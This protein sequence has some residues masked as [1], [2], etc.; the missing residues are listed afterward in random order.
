LLIYI[1]IYMKNFFFLM[2]HI[3]SWNNTSES[4]WN[5]RNVLHSFQIIWNF[6]GSLSHLPPPH[7]IVPRT[8]WISRVRLASC[9]PCSRRNDLSTAYWIYRQYAN[10]VNGTRFAPIVCVSWARF[11]SILSFLEK[12]KSKI[13]P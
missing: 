2:L 8:S 4:L 1:Y 11:H 6:L 3:N 5:H 13:K 10:F 12:E 9:I 7:I